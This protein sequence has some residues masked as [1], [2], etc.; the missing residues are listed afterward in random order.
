MRWI[1]ATLVGLLALAYALLTFAA[2]S[3]AVRPAP[4]DTGLGGLSRLAF[5]LREAGYRI[6]F[7]PSTRPRLAKDDV[8]AAPPPGEI[9][10][11]GAART[12]ARWGG[13]AW[14]LSVPRSLQ[15][16]AETV[17]AYDVLRREAKVDRTAFV[18]PNP[19]RP[20]GQLS[21][22]EA[23]RLGDDTTLAS[24]SQL[25]EGRMAR[26]AQ[27]ALA[28]NRFLGRQENARV[29]FSTLASVAQRGDRLV[30]VAGGYGEAQNVGPLEAIGPWAI[31]ALWQ[32]FALMAA[33]GIFRGIRFGL[34]APERT[35]KRGARELLDAIA[36]FYRRGKRTDAATAAAA[37]ERPGDSEAQALAARAKVPEAEAQRALEALDARP[38]TRR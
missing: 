13:R 38:K 2:P 28:T 15:S 10:I 23:W 4:D 33:F 6:S 9:A 30:F 35:T 11:P 12:R 19:E 34:P 22:V 27:G 24:L 5:A 31:G 14:I 17:P 37:R 8:V 20:K 16:I 32:G 18:S 3:V 7:D 29:V 21:S 26:L 25:G 36:A 1:A